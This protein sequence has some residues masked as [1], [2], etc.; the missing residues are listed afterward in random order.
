VGA[1][2]DLGRFEAPAAG[3][4]LPGGGAGNEKRDKAGAVRQVFDE[5][6]AFMVEVA[7]RDEHSAAAA[8]QLA[9]G[10]G[11]AAARR[12]QQNDN[13]LGIA[14]RFCPALVNG[15]KDRGQGHRILRV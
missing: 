13:A 11:Q 8:Q 14:N 4:T 15:F 1:P 6:D 5:R 2:S 9:M 12:P 7:D 10:Q 3:P